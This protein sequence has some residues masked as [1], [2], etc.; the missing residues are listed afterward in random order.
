MTRRAASGRKWKWLIY[1]TR[2]TAL[3]TAALGTTALATAALATT[4]RRCVIPWYL[5]SILL[6][7]L[8]LGHS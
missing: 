7:L 5:S 4:V 6:V 1:R 8:L 3:A 2:S